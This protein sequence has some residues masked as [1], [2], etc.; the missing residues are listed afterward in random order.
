MLKVRI[1]G[2]LVLAAC[3]FLAGCNNGPK[4]ETTSITASPMQATT[5]DVLKNVTDPQGDPLIIK[6]VKGAEKGS[7]VLNSDN[8]ITYTPRGGTSGTDEFSYRVEDNRG[9]G[10]N[11]K[12]LVS[13]EDRTPMV[14][15][16]PPPT[17]I[18]GSP[19]PRPAVPV[20]AAAPVAL[21]PLPMMTPPPAQPGA[22]IRSALIILRTTG[23]AKDPQDSVRVIL[24]S[25]DQVLGDNIVGVGE[26]WTSASDRSFEMPLNPPVPLSA[27]SHM[28]LEIDKPSAQ[29]QGASW[30]T[31]VEMTG[32]LTDGRNVT[33]LPQTQPVRLGGGNPSQVVLAVPGSH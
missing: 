24:R 33:L 12:V 29:Q 31:Q 2:G 16:V 17:P 6:K 3:A 32:R 4:A 1:T 23:T 8:S 28:T 14:V 11:G 9:H 20:A 22:M 7:V 15:P 5:V 26:M 13:I 18:Y 21:V 30:T 10:A 19:E 27:S 25:D